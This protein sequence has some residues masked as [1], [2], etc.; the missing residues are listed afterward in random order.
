VKLIKKAIALAASKVQEKKYEDI[1]LICEQVLKVDFDNL[2]ALYLLSIAKY[3]LN[4]KEEF[5]TYF[6]KLLNLSPNDFEANNSLGLSYLHLGNLDKAIEHFKKATEIDPKNYIGWS[7]LG[8]QYRA[9]KV[10]NKAIECLLKSYKLNKKN[11]QTLINLAGAFAEKLEI[12]KSIFYLKKALAINPKSAAAHVDLGCAYYLLGDY[13]KAWKHYQ[14]RFK[15]YDYLEARIKQLDKNKK[16]NGKKIKDNET[17]LFFSEQ[18]VGDCINFIRFTDNFRKENPKVKIKIL[19]PSSLYELLS[20]N[21]YGIIKSIEDHD[22]WCSI[23][24]LPHY[25]GM[26]AEDIG[27]SY[28]PYIKEIE[29]CDYSYF[30]D[31][32]KIG[33]CWAG[34]PQHPRDEERSCYLSFFKEIYKIPKVKLFSLQ[35]DLRPRIWPFQENSIDLAYCE[36]LKMIDMSKYMNSWENTASIVSGLDLVITVDTS[37]LHLAGAIG[38]KTYGILPY[39]PDWRWSLDL[40]KTIWYPSVKLFRK[41]SQND[42]YSVFEKIKKNINIDI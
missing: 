36:D 9:K 14:Y 26:S 30:K 7:N 38:K 10:F 28:K 34:N 24:D 13:E 40:E 8:C 33:I 31:Y 27:N 1:E 25:L 29:K 19:V 37:I 17:I 4:K 22:H 12:K 5:E 16:W 6:N 11:H 42:W 2:D 20:H 18:G 35:K 15:Y 21:F 23:M 3:K 41:K 39:F 32:Y